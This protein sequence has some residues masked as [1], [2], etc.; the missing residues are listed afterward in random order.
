MHAIA[1]EVLLKEGV[2]LDAPWEVR[3][4]ER[5]SIVVAEGIAVV[6]SAEI[7][8]EVVRDAL[9]L[10]PRVVAFLE[11]GFAGMDTLKANAFTKARELGI[12]MKTV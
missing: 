10:R 1:A 12:T 7:A 2:T 11:D 3:S 8:E 9:D 5:G 6:C 4:I